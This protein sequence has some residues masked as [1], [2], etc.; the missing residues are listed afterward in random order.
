VNERLLFHGTPP[1][2]A[3]EIVR[4]GFDFRLVTTAAYGNGA[5]FSVRCVG[6]AACLALGTAA[7]CIACCGQLL[8]Q[9]VLTLLLRLVCALAPHC[10]A[11]AGLCIGRSQATKLTA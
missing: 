9:A 7:C 3:Q 2:A 11:P 10:L 5:Y 1:G 4:Q 8:R 6:A